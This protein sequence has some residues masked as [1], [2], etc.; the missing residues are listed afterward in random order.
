MRRDD[1]RGSIGIA[2]SAQG[3][4]MAR[5]PGNGFAGWIPLL[6]GVRS[7]VSRRRVRWVGW[8]I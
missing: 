7:A 4:G 8:E 3:A 6:Q 1:Y 5:L 2:E